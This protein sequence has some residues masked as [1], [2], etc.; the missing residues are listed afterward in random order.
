M[1]AMRLRGD[2]ELVRAFDKLGPVGEAKVLG[3]AATEAAEPIVDD[4]RGRAPS[5]TIR[6]GVR[7][8]GVESNERG[9]VTVKVGLPGGRHPWFH[10]LFIELGT[11]PRVQKST[12]RRTGSMPADPFLRPALDA[13]RDRA[14]AIFASEIRRRLMEIARG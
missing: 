11:G 12:G 8:L 13:Q 10:G 1:I 3:E 2:R 14:Q 9:T 4:A 5:D 6:D 7:F